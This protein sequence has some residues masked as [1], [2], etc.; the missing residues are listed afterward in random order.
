M[1]KQ[2]DA[3][4]LKTYPIVGRDGRIVHVTI[5]ESETT[6]AIDCAIEQ[7]YPSPLTTRESSVVQFETRDFVRAHGRRPSG[8][9][10]WAFAAKPDF[11]SDDTRIFWTNGLYSDAKR[12]AAKHFAKQSVK[13]VYVYS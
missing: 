2:S 12:E 8:R 13:L 7:T 11:E 9:G 6:A 5:P 10:S 1:T 4:K 3:K